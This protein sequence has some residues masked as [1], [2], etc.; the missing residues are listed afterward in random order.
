[1]YRLSPAVGV[2]RVPSP[3]HPH[4]HRAIRPGLR[5]A[6]GAD[7]AL[8]QLPLLGGSVGADALQRPQV[9]QH[10]A[11]GVGVDNRLAPPQLRLEDVERLG[12]AVDPLDHRAHR[13]TGLVVIPRTV[14]LV[15]DAR[16]R[17][18]GDRR[19]AAA[20]GEVRIVA[21]T[22]LPRDRRMQERAVVLGPLVGLQPAG[23]V[24]IDQ[25]LAH[26]QPGRAQRGAIRTELAP[27][28]ALARVE[29]HGSKAAG[30]VEVVVDVMRIK[31]RVEGAVARPT[32]QPGLDLG[33]QRAEVRDVALVEGPGTLGQH[34][35]GAVGHARDDDAAGVAPEDVD[36]DLELRGRFGVGR[37]GGM[38][39]ARCLGR[40]VAALLDAELAVRV[41]GW[42]AGLVQP[43]LLDIL[44][45][46][47]LL[48]PGE[49]GLGIAGDHVAEGG[50]L[51]RGQ[52]GFEPL[53]AG[54]EQEL[55]GGVRQLTQ[56]AAELPA[57]RDAGGHVEAAGRRRVG[58]AGE[59]EPVDQGRVFQQIGAQVA[60]EPLVLLELDQVGRDEGGAGLRGWP[61]PGAVGRALGEL[62][63]GQVA[64]QGAVLL[65]HRV[66]G[67]PG[68]QDGVRLGE[69]T[70]DLNDDGRA[71]RRAAK[72]GEQPVEDSGECRYHEEAPGCGGVV[73]GIAILPHR[74]PHG[75]RRGIGNRRRPGTI[76]RRR[77][78]GD[79]LRPTRIVC[80][81]APGA[82]PPS[83]R[84]D[85]P[86]LTDRDLMF[87]P[88]LMKGFET[89]YDQ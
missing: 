84:P 7:L 50:L 20:L 54:R 66:G 73:S 69:R 39:G 86:S 48:D 64:E 87:S 88:S 15:A 36:P 57:R 75:K 14:K 46:V 44:L 61:R 60:H 79:R 45:G 3:A 67:D 65:H 21:G 33:Q 49:D 13:I 6:V 25:L 9:D 55:Q 58:H 31:R 19:R 23:A 52:S 53:D 59:A 30:L 24:E 34:D 76:C 74:E 5:C 81:A 38:V 27:R 71:D 63:P 47:V 82:D 40:G 35:L 8:G 70:R 12:L 28:A 51:R 89:E 42:L 29:R 68:G 32:A 22:G 11:Q 43:P 10:V 56:H 2:V 18:V 85:P 77:P 72:R 80:Q 26:G 1:M 16:A 17:G 62:A 4:H 37:R 83:P 41:A 78:T